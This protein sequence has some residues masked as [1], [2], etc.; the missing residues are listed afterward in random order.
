MK[1]FIFVFLFLIS[2]GGFSQPKQKI[3]ES[4]YSNN[5]IEMA[6]TMRQDGKIYVVVAILAT[7][8]IGILIYAAKLDMDISR[9]EKEIKEK[10]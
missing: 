8:M 9:L 10:Q 2:I 7:V 4:D 6:D 1:K 3:S 5:R